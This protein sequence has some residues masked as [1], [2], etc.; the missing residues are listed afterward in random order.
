MRRTRTSSVR[1][2]KPM[3]QDMAHKSQAPCVRPVY[4]CT[5]HVFHLTPVRRPSLPPLHSL[6]CLLIH[7]LQRLAAGPLDAR[8]TLGK[9]RGGVVEIFL[10][11]EAERNLF[12]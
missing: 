10:G 6:L 9:L 11:L 8:E 4:L 12:G 2:V 5:Q 3:A 7:L 1:R